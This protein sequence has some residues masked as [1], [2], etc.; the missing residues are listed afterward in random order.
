MVNTLA[1]VQYSGNNRKK[2]KRNGCVAVD[3]EVGVLAVDSDEGVV[4][5]ESEETD[6]ISINDQEVGDHLNIQSESLVD[7]QRRKRQDKRKGKRI[8]LNTKSKE[9]K[10][11]KKE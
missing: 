6:A 7:P 11:E 9:K 1:D 5:A 3:K 8:L 2:K 4:A 10:N